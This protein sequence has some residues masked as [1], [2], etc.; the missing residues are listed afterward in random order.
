MDG[1]ITFA[2]TI[3]RSWPSGFVLWYLDTEGIL[4]LWLKNKQILPDCSNGALNLVKWI[5]SVAQDNKR[6]RK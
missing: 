1:Y 5:L 3:S 2:E 6:E 4:I